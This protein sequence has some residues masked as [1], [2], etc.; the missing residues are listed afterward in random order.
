MVELL[1]E[2]GADV[3]ALD[4]SGRTAAKRAALAEHPEVAVVLRSRLR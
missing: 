2:L 1:V 4:A 3:H